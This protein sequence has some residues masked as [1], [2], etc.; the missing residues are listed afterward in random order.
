MQG[1]V[2]ETDVPL[3]PR[4][5]PL[6]ALGRRLDRSDFYTIGQIQ[7]EQP[8][9]THARLAAAASLRDTIISVEYV[10]TTGIFAGHEITIDHATKGPR[11]YRVVSSY[12]DEGVQK[13]L[14]NPP[15][16]EGAALNADVTIDRPKC[17]MR[18]ATETE[19]ELMFTTSPRELITVNFVEAF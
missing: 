1:I 9:Y 12:E 16:R 10:D 17:R 8:P 15:L 5:I 13:L 11:A 18:L 19:G 4:I 7:V 14:I 2:G 6:D 3:W